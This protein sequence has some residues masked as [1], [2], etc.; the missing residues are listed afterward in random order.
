MTTIVAVEGTDGVT[1]A[2]DTRMSGRVINDG[3]VS[4]VF[5]NG[6]LVFGVA[7]YLRVSQLMK[8]T[9]LPELPKSAKPEKIDAWVT[10][11]LVPIWLEVNKYFSDGDKDLRYGSGAIV[12]VRNRVYELDSGG[13]WSRNTSGNYSIGSGSKYALGALSAGAS[14]K[15]AV[16]IAALY[17]AGTNDTVS[18]L[19]VKSQS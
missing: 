18:V 4:K 9:D 14:A 10:H 1:L 3:W 5:H 12:V 13:G 8:Y 17:D 2:S 6:E 16:R 11:K 15:R 7:G 19:K